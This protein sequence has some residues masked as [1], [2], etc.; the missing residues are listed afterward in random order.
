MNEQ[1]RNFAPILSDNFVPKW[2]G[3]LAPI[4]SLRQSGPQPAKA[5]G[6]ARFYRSKKLRL[7]TI[8]DR[9]GNGVLHDPAKIGTSVFD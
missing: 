9:E 7:R 4:E 2:L 5:H 8:L 3:S 1:V 6:L